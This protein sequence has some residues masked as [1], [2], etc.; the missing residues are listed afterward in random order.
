MFNNSHWKESPSLQSPPLPIHAVQPSAA[1]AAT[2]AAAAIGAATS[3]AAATAATPIGATATTT[4]LAGARRRGG[5]SRKSTTL[6]NVG[7]GVALSTTARVPTTR[8]ADVGGVERQFL[9]ALRLVTHMRRPEIHA[10]LSV[11]PPTGILVHGPPG[12]GKQRFVEALAGELELPLLRVAATELIAGVSGETEEKIRAVFA[13]ARQQ[14]PL[15]LLFDDVDVL[16]PRRETAQR[17]MERRIVTQLINSLDG[18][19]QPFFF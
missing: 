11:A 13:Q 3:T 9:D 14:A 6:S 8:L 10:Q 16:A 7:G 4:T 2:T 15:V 18:K 1:A 19:Q 5:G 17:E 12:C